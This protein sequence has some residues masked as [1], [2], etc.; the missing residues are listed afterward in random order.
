[1]P[2]TDRPVF[3]PLLLSGESFYG[4]ST[5]QVDQKTRSKVSSSVVAF[6]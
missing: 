4:Q 1:M 6:I 3:A 5:G 2:Q